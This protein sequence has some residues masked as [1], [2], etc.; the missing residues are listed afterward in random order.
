MTDSGPVSTREA[1]ERHSTRAPSGRVGV[2]AQGDLFRREGRRFK[3]DVGD[4][5]P[6]VK[7]GAFTGTRAFANNTARRKQ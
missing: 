2:A 7:E 4:P 1:L 3:S 6:T 5:T